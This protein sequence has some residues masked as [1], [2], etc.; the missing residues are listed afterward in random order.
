ME[1][2]DKTE[3]FVRMFEEAEEATLTARGNAERDRDYYDGK[4]LTD[5]EVKA[6]R[7]RGQPPL[8]INRIRRKIDWL[9]GFEIQRRTEPKAIPRNPTSEHDA[10]SATDSIR[11]VCDNVNWDKIRSAVH[12]NLLIEGIGGVEVVHEQKGDEIEVAINRYNWDRLFYDP[13]SMEPDFSDARYLGAVIW[14][15]AEELKNMEGVKS[16][17]VEWTLQEAG[18]SDTYDDRPKW[19]LWGDNKRKRVRVVLLHYKEGGKW[20]WCRYFKGG[21]IDKGE[22][23]YKDEDGNTVCPLIMASLYVDRDNN[24]YGVVRDM[25]DPQD[26]INKRRSKALHQLTMRQA[27]MEQ[28]AVD[29]MEDV[30][31]EL[32]RPD[33]I[34]IKQPDMGFEILDQS[35]L[36][37]GQMAL[38][39]EAKSEID[40]MGANSAL[41]GETGESASGRAVIAKQQG[42]IIEFAGNMDRLG[43]FSNEVYRQIWMRIR[44]FWTEERWIRVTDDDRNVRFV[45]L[46]K[47]MTLADE[48]REAPQEQAM[49]AAQQM[50]LRPDDP[51]LN[52]VTRIQNH[53]AKLE[54]DIE[55]EEVP[56]QIAVS[57]EEFQALANMGPALIQS[58]PMYAAVV[59]EM[60][61]ET[62]PG[63]SADTRDKL[64]QMTQQIEQQN[65]QASAGAQ[66]TEQMQGQV[67]L[68]KASADI[69]ATTAKAAKDE[70]SA[71]QMLQGDVA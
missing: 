41:A 4:Q 23:P 48:L 17:E 63:L 14:M 65:L 60:L 64:R 26:E 69:R 71:L 57:A 56:D 51:R 29:S 37:S 9:K 67:A 66:Q 52:Q 24:R 53:I 42:G 58:N 30:R 8:V 15:D 18:T 10:D 59:N 19:S 16:L 22:S 31:R 54:V 27:V 49:Q 13:H 70:A 6:L 7:K 45:G 3:R 62:A 44:Q 46:N 5:D 55:I 47:P 34:I 39:Q 40:M 50:G 21:I 61:I 32:A 35:Q 36:A 1:Y 33:G 20:H 43:M 28:G 38:L 2:S 25:I 11:F 68:E 12:E